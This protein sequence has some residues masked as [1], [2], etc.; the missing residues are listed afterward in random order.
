MT[1]P[2]MPDGLKLQVL[3][4]IHIKYSDFENKN[5]INYLNF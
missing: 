5:S 4:F 2:L 1:F 3:N